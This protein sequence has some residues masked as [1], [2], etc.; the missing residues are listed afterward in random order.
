MF[1]I[2]IIPTNSHLFELKIYMMLKKNVFIRHFLIISFYFM[3]NKQFDK[4]NRIHKPSFSM[5]D[6]FIGK[7]T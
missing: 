4:K 7:F 2:K 3:A 1:I 5:F 6:Q